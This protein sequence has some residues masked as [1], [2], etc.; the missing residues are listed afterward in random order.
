MLTTG[1]QHPGIITG[2]RDR[3]GVEGS[4][5]Q[6]QQGGAGYRPTQGVY[7]ALKIQ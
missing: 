7:N 1:Q 5:E 3:R 4:A 6:V 2:E